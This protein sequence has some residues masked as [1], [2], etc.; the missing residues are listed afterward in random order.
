MRPLA[1]LKSR[2]YSVP[3]WILIS[4]AAFIVAIAVAF[5]VPYYRLSKRVDRQL[6]A[7]AFQHT[8][9]YFAAP[10]IV[11]VGDPV[12][13]E[14]VAALKRAAAHSTTPVDIQVSNGAISSITD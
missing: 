3:R 11:T 9:T 12:P 14:D 8:F 13:L 6:A 7:G 10:E 1:D 2:L 5:A 4:A